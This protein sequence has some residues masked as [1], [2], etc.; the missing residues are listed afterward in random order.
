MTCAWS[1]MAGTGI[2][3]RGWWSISYFLRENRAQNKWPHRHFF[4]AIVCGVGILGDDL[5]AHYA[6]AKQNRQSKQTN[7]NKHTP[8]PWNYV[9]S[10]GPESW[11]VFDCGERPGSG[12]PIADIRANHG[13]NAQKANARLIAAAPELL[14]ALESLYKLAARVGEPEHQAMEAARAAIKKCQA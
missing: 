9:L 7:M 12:M 8:G 4:V 6:R 2:A 14:A 3:R 1:R 10:S 11:I 5:S 13:E